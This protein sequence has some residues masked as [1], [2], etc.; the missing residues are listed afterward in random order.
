[1]RWWRV[2]RVFLR[3]LSVTLIVI[4]GGFIFK[5][6]M[7]NDNPLVW[8]IKWRE[9]CPNCAA[10]QQLQLFEVLGYPEEHQWEV[11]LEPTELTRALNLA[12]P[13][14]CPDHLFETVTQDC[15]LVAL[16]RWP[17]FQHFK[18]G[19][20]IPELITALRSRQ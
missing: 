5:I 1:M 16:T 3:R 15:L 18:N 8:R 11:S 2:R 4:L 7:A 10:S 17:P 13:G 14:K 20:A 19:L 9:M 6:I 12:A